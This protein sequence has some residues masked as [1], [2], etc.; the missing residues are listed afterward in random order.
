MKGNKITAKRSIESKEFG[1]FLKFIEMQKMRNKTKADAILISSLLWNTGARISEILELTVRDLRIAL[2]ISIVKEGKG[3]DN[4]IFAIKLPI[5]K[6][7]SSTKKFKTIPLLYESVLKLRDVFNNWLKAVKKYSISDDTYLF[8]PQGKP[9]DSP[10]IRGWT[11]R[12]NE[13]IRSF[14]PI[15]DD[16]E[17]KVSSHSFRHAMS[18]RLLGS[19]IREFERNAILGHTQKTTSERHYSNF[20]SKGGKYRNLVNLYVSIFE[21]FST[22]NIYGFD[23]ARRVVTAI[24]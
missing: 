24:G 23:E 18:E 9:T 6:S 20:N 5:N 4:G 11:T 15:L 12:F 13:L 19:A 3:F 17:F 10:S 2:T 16:D 22:K 8:F 7:K 21:S 14:F 1:E